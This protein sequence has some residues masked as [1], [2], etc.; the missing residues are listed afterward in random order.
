MNKIFKEH[1][2]ESSQ[3]LNKINSKKIKIID[4]RWY[5]NNQKKG[6]EEYLKSHILNSIFF[7]LEKYSNSDSQLPHMLPSEKQFKTFVTEMGISKNNEIIIYDQTGFF[8][9][10][11]VWFI[12][13][14]FKFK[15]I[16]ILNGGFQ[17][18][19][20]KKYPVSK[21]V[22][23]SKKNN[24]KIVAKKNMVIEKKEIEKKLLSNKKTL[25]LDA[26][27][28][29]RFYGYEKEPRKDVKNG[30]IPGSLNIPFD[31]ISSKNGKLLSFEKL[32]KIF[33]EKIPFSKTKEIFNSPKEKATQDYISGKFGL[34]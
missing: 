24:Q 4:C 31:K 25:I 21:I 23:K 17:D 33:E 3:L 14:Y 26:R 19:F 16:K 6:Y 10:S 5:L 8:C 12:F 22:I 13:K 27:P 18:W 11:R 7:D 34:S 20:K 2:L 28:K 29:K 9:S 15:S 1:I 32:N 30:N